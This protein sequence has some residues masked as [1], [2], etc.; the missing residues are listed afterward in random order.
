[1]K[2]IISNLVYKASRSDPLLR[3]KLVKCGLPTAT[4][5]RRWPCNG[6]GGAGQL[7]PLGYS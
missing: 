5:Q 3:V 7:E 1:M 6:Y 4:A 2:P